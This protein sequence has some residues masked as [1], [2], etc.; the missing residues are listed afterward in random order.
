ME[1][2]EQDEGEGESVPSSCKKSTGLWLL[3]L[4][5][6]RLLCGFLTLSDHLTDKLKCFRCK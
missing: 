5:V 1:E 3:C 4:L 2:E 6:A